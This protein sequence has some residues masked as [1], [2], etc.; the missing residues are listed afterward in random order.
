MLADK[1]QTGLYKYIL[2]LVYYVLPNMR[3]L[4]YRD[5]LKQVNPDIL[6]VSLY[7]VGY[8]LIIVAISNIIF[9]KKKYNI[10]TKM[11]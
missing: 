9:S 10:N 11:K 4:N 1:V 3:T 6:K 7:A 5:Y 2:E 8:I